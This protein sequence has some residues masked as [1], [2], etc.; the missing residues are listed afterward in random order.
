MKIDEFAS[1]ACF[2]VDP[3]I[4]WDHKT[5]TRPGTYVGKVTGCRHADAPIDPL[6]NRRKEQP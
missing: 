6:Y 1:Q 3:A 2:P 5:V 4:G